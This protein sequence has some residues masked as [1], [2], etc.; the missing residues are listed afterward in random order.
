[1]GIYFWVCLN[2]SKYFFSLDH[3]CKTNNE[4]VKIKF[5]YPSLT[6]S[7]LLLLSYCSFPAKPNKKNMFYGK[8]GKTKCL[9]SLSS[10]YQ[11]TQISMIIIIIITKTAQIKLLYHYFQNVIELMV[12]FS[13]FNFFI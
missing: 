5:H 10:I 2:N 4:I 11:I 3:E 7:L 9:S 6:L 12:D 13:A 1:M 8:I